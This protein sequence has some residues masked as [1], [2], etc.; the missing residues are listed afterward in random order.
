MQ[1]IFSHDAAYLS[2]CNFS[3][4][5]YFGSRTSNGFDCTS[6]WSLVILYSI[7]H[8]SFHHNNIGELIFSIF[9]FFI[10]TAT[11]EFDQKSNEPH[12]E[13]SYIDTTLTLSTS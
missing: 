8:S 6:S 10:I 11:I 7:H 5:I 2:L 1:N 13:K 9:L 3:F 4:P 12:H